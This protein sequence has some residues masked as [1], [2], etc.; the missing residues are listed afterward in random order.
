MGQDCGSR[1]PILREE[2]EGVEVACGVELHRLSMQGRCA[3][4]SFCFVLFACGPAT[5]D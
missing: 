4:A 5:C 3:R 2:E 1:E